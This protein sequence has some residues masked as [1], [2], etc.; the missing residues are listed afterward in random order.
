MTLVAQ[1]GVCRNC[2]HLLVRSA[3]NPLEASGSRSIRLE[4]RRSI[5]WKPVFDNLLKIHRTSTTPEPTFSS[6]EDESRKFAEA[7]VRRLRE[8]KD[9]AGRPENPPPAPAPEQLRRA[10]PSE[11]KKFVPQRSDT[12]QNRLGHLLLSRG[13][14]LLKETQPSKPDVS[15]RRQ[16][17]AIEKLD[18][19]AFSKPQKPFISPLR[20]EQKEA[21]RKYLE[22]SSSQ[23]EPSRRLEKYPWE[24]VPIPWDT[25]GDKLKSVRQLLAYRS[26]QMSERTGRQPQITSSSALAEDYKKPPIEDRHEFDILASVH[27]LKSLRVSKLYQLLRDHHDRSWRAWNNRD[28]KLL[29]AAN[30]DLETQLNISMRQLEERYGTVD[31]FEMFKT[32]LQS[33]LPRAVHSHSMITPLIQYMLARGGFRPNLQGQHIIDQIPEDFHKIGVYD[34]FNRIKSQVLHE[35]LRTGQMPISET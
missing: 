14:T 24:E 31:W 23:K 4:S 11:S 2:G 25:G 33:L 32:L 30:L 10:T 7:A 1:A 6:S 16:R 13:R 27:L 19:L 29:A 3:A 35:I 22:M 34:S 17:G 20:S 9:R 18:H 26:P 21:L 28:T 8:A 15:L 12:L 5:W